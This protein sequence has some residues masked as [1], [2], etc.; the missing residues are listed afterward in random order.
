MTNELCDKIDFKIKRVFN[1]AVPIDTCNFR[2]HYCYI[3]HRR[4]F[5]RKLPIFKHTP[6]QMA[7]AFSKERFRGTCLINLCAGGETLLAPEMPKIV[8]RLLEEEHIILVV[9]NGSVSK[10]FD[11]FVKFSQKLRGRLFIKFSF[12]YLELLRLK[13]L[14]K[15]FEN[16][17][18]MKANGISFTVE[19]TPCDELIPYIEDIKKIC[20]ERVG[21]LPH[22][23]I[24]RD[25]RDPNFP[26]LTKLS[27][28]E[29]KKLW[30]Q[31]NSMFFEFKESV[32]GVKQNDF[33]YAGTAT[34]SANLDNGK[35][36]QCD[37]EK[38]L[39]N[40]YRRINQPIREKP[41]GNHCS[42]PHCWNAHYWMGFGT[43]PSQNDHVPFYVEM[44]NRIC[45]D[46]T[47]WLIGDVKKA[48]S[49]RLDD[50]LLIHTVTSNIN[51]IG[52]LTLLL[53]KIRNLKWRIKNISLTKN[54]LF[55]H[56]VKENIK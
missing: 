10:S 45:N 34:Y 28:I 52:F 22:V 55:S 40:L 19:L 31:F 23:T 24:A 54:N 39:M 49:M 5:S 15:F 46:G 9:T 25:E 12:H 47:E 29:Y 4:L 13:L 50:G 21:A 53:V 48:F 38:T 16:V 18:K 32:F 43:I 27:R 33:C 2:C 51:E 7:R 26:I 35:L 8:K 56:K 1:V 41:I 44:R 20:I 14:D 30:S 17:Q 11:E 6:E 42:A 36:K 3:T 37:R